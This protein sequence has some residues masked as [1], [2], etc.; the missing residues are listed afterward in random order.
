[1][2]ST[3][4]SATLHYLDEINNHFFTHLATETTNEQFVSCLSS[5]TV[6]DLFASTRDFK[7]S[8]RKYLQGI[9]PYDFAGLLS[10]P[11]RARITSS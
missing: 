3:T 7:N 10:S 2:F 6:L 8:L 1:M 11:L 9:T 5:C 4:Y